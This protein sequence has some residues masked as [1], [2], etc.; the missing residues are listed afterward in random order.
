MALERGVDAGGDTGNCKRTIGT[1]STHVYKHQTLMQIYG[2]QIKVRGQELCQCACACAPVCA[3]QLLHEPRPSRQKPS[4]PPPRAAL[5]REHL[6]I[7]RPPPPPEPPLKPILVYRSDTCT[8]RDT[9][10]IAKPI[11]T[12]A[13]ESAIIYIYIFAVENLTI[14][15][16]FFASKARK[17]QQPT[18][19]S[20]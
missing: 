15:L 5:D 6:T 11:P 9:H 13:I 17:P 20:L 2:S 19:L 3:P 1:V 8:I 4:L 16:W 18:P 14:H 10:C 12:S 7:E